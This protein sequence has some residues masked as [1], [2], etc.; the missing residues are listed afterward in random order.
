MQQ[1]VPV[2]RRFDLLALGGS[3]LAL[4]MALMYLVLVFQEDGDPAD[5]AVAI[6]VGSGVGAGYSASRQ[7]SHRRFVLW[8]CA[9]GLIALGYLAILT[10]GLPILLAGALCLAAA[11][12]ARK[13]KD[14]R[15]TV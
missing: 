15:D 4:A 10:I 6:L 1:T 9:V 3:V 11:L 7:A 5:W 13:A 12:R 8:L 2:T 14:W